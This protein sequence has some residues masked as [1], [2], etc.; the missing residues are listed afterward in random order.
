[1]L[2]LSNV[3][4]LNF[5]LHVHQHCPLNEIGELLVVINKRVRIVVLRRDVY[6]LYEL[7]EG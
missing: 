4:I 6:Q 5:E 1:M 2:R 3:L 7:I